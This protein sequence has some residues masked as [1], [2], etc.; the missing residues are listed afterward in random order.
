M[1]MIKDKN[2]LLEMG[3]NA[4]SISTADAEEKIYNEIKKLVK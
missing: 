2:E 1:E 3:K 4:F